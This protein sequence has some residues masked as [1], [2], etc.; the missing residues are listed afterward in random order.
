MH[1]FQK[2]VSDLYSAYIKK[3]VIHF[4]R[5]IVLK[6]IHFDICMWHISKEQLI[7]FSLVS[8]LYHV[9]HAWPSTLPLKMSMSLSTFCKFCELDKR[10]IDKQCNGVAAENV[11]SQH[12]FPF[13]KFEQHGTCNFSLWCWGSFGR[14]WQELIDVW[15][16]IWL[17]WDRTCKICGHRCQLK[18]VVDMLKMW[19][20]KRTRAENKSQRKVKSMP[21]ICSRPAADLLH[22][23]SLRQG[24]SFVCHR[25]R[26]CRRLAAY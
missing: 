17:W 14:I 9:C 19:V 6:S 16:V 25:K 13:W 8:F 12:L 10:V 26:T 21:Q 11:T 20:H 4:H 7:L 24:V 18:S 5:P 1:C 15:A 2:L 23:K 3:K 22:T